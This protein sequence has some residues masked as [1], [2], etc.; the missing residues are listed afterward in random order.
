MVECMRTSLCTAFVVKGRIL[1]PP[2][3]INSSGSAQTWVIVSFWFATPWVT[4]LHTSMLWK[5]SFYARLC[6]K[7]A[8][9]RHS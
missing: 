1:I 7:F 3:S 6:W 9:L 4:K 2:L 8:V 5:R